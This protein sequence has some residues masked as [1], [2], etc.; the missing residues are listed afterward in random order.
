MNL[1]YTPKINSEIYIL[2]PDES[3]HC[4]KV[5][6]LKIGDEIFLTDGKGNLYKCELIEDNPKKCTVRVIDIQKEYEKREVKIHI[7]VAPTKNISRFEWFLE[8]AT[9]IGV[10]EITPIICEHSERRIIKHD[11]LNKIITAALKQSLKA[12]HPVL[13]EMQTFKK[14]MDLDFAGEKYIGFCEDNPEFLKKVYPKGKD[15]LIM[16]GPEG[17]FS[18]KEIQIAKEKGFIPISLGGSRLRT[19]TAAVVACH[20]INFMNE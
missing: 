10:D 20:S 2:D 12:Y 3:R 14:F 16:I 4:L 18:K 6:R 5:L 8:K 9:E 1:F 15:V 13:N 7:A 17:D 11:R 19:E